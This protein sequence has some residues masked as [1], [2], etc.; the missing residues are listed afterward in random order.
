MQYQ[1]RQER[2]MQ[3]SDKPVVK[4]DNKIYR[5]QNPARS[6]LSLGIFFLFKGIISMAVKKA[7]KSYPKTN[8]IFGKVGG[9]WWNPEY[10]I[11]VGGKDKKEVEAAAQMIQ[12]SF[13]RKKKK[14]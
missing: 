2:Q 1:Y 9:S 8:I 13:N 14:K 4:G 10:R 11:V 12:N 7:A 5:V 3:L 6:E